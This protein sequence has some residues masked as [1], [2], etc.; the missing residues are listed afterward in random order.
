MLKVERDNEDKDFR[1]AAVQFVPGIP[2]M[3]LSV[4]QNRQIKEG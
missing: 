1:V 2:A 4:N 3:T